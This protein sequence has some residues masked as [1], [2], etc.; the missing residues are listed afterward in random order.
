MRTTILLAG[1]V[2]GVALVVGCAPDGLDDADGA[3]ADVADDADA[4]VDIEADLPTS[5][6]AVRIALFDE[7]GGA[8]GSKLRA[9][10]A[11]SVLDGDSISGFKLAGAPFSF[12]DRKVNDVV[13]PAADVEFGA[14]PA[15]VLVD[16]DDGTG[17]IAFPV[18]LV[19]AADVS[20][21]TIGSLG[22]LADAAP[23]GISSYLGF[24]GG[25]LQIETSDS[26]TGEPSKFLATPVSTV[27]EYRAYD[28]TLDAPYL[29][30][31]SVQ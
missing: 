20:L 29:M 14:P 23:L 6:T 3:A 22:A 10:P 2:A 15:E 25:R 9:W 21:T 31:A 13:A 7:G 18:V 5:P 30:S 1:A 11:W 19:V 24:R 26:E 12:V 27:A 4:D 16:G 28:E 8:D 17:S